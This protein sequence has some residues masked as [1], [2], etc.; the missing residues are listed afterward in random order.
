MYDDFNEALMARVDCEKRNVAVLIYWLERNR[1]S[2]LY[3]KNL[4]QEGI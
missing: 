1:A 3:M 2:V 4:L